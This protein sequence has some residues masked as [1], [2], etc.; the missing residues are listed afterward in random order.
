MK[1]FSISRMNDGWF[2]FLFLVSSF[3]LSYSSSPYTVKSWVFV[4]G[5][6]L[7]FL[8]LLLKKNASPKAKEDYYRE[9]FS[10]SKNILLLSAVMAAALFLRFYR[11]CDFYI[12]PTGDEGLHG[13][14]ATQLAQKWDWQ[15]FYTVGEHPPL[16]IWVLSFFFGSFDSPFFDLWF[17]PAVLSTLFAGMGYLTARSFFSR[18]FSCLFGGLA[19]FSFWPLYFGRFCHQGIFIPFWEI[20]AFFLLAHWIKSK[21]RKNE[22][23]WALALGLW[24]G[25]GSLTFPTWILTAFVVSVTVGVLFFKRSKIPFTIFLLGLGFALMPFGLAV[26]TEGYGHHLLD[27]S[28]LGQMSSGPRPLI[29]HL[30]YLT[31]LFW[32]P[33]QDGIS[34]G[35]RWGGMLN[36]ILDSFFLIGIA[37]LYRG[38]NKPMARW[39]IF[40][41]FVSLL[42]A[43]LAADYV[44]L[45]RLIQVM[46]VLLFVTAMGIQSL[47]LGTGNKYRKPILLILI[48]LS[49]GFDLVHLMKGS[50][51]DPD[52]KKQALDENSWA[53]SRLNSA[54]LENGPGLIFPD[55]LTL[56][57]GHT[58][59]VTTYHFNAAVNPR[60]N[61]GTARWVGIIANIHYRPFLKARFP[62]AH[63][64]WCEAEPSRREGGL[65]LGIVP[66][67]EKDQD[68]FRHWLVVH[69][70]FHQQNLN[71]E[72]SFNGK[73]YYLEA[74]RHLVNGRSLVAGDRF[75]ESCYG[76]WAA[77]YFY[78]P[79]YEKNAMI[80]RS[81]IEKGYPAA[82]LYEK[83]GDFLST[84]RQDQ[85]AAKAYETASVLKS[86]FSR[87]RKE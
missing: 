7:P 71:A 75:L 64:E 17:L 29:T 24:T 62:E 13:F 37:D 36:P 8:F 28:A 32:G 15:F 54:F 70:F 31:S 61:P 35:P 3:M 63:W 11:L 79:S 10:P 30:S 6:T 14:L 42:P 21:K 76:E 59:Y 66:I 69:D 67:N 4:A 16:L 22:R 73:K 72:K 12:W 44:E 87:D 39:V 45:N 86:E 65:V 60:F 34:Y 55:Y 80:M 48:L 84:G 18:S 51:L 77:Q 49:S 23:K 38:R 26:W 58:L 5:I 20:T 56:D 25:V 52:S 53:Y 83:L 68:I 33:L 2:F 19:A 81:T 43:F 9:S 1:S 47:I 85:E 74:S 57:H 27:S 41:L 40:L 78:D 50:T 46:P 82:H